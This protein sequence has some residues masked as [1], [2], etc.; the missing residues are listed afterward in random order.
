MRVPLS[1]L[2]VFFSSI[3]FS[4]QVFAKETASLVGS[5][6][7][8]NMNATGMILALLLVLAVIIG[9]AFLLK[10]FN[11]IQG[12]SSNLRV[13]TSLSLSTKEKII[14]V[15]VGKKQL[16]LGV[17]AQQINLLETLETP[18]EIQSTNTA[19]VGNSFLNR[20]SKAMAPHNVDLKNKKPS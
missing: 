16:L 6:V 18:I 15:Q 8:G 10:R 11:F 12:S 9:S 2:G 1:L 19:T 20:L 14:V 4:S 7:A 3:V 17:T 13:V 5:Q